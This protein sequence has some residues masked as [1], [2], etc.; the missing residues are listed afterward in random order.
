MGFVTCLSILILCCN[1][2]KRLVD[3]SQEV[4]FSRRGVGQ[5]GIGWVVQLR[6]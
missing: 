1:Q 2:I 6:A 3:F 4:K 5:K